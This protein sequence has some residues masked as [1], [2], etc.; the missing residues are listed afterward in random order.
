M[1]SDPTI[2][3]QSS[4]HNTNDPEPYGSVDSSTQATSELT[5]DDQLSALVAMPSNFVND[6][7]CAQSLNNSERL[8]AL[9]DHFKPDKLY[10]FSNTHRVQKAT[11]LQ[12][13]L[14]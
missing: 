11:F 10:D 2:L 1:S 3:S 6:I 9:Q 5:G 8:C 12:T 4:H 14:A 7:D 13:L